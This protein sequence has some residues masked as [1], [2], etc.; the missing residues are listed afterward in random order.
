MAE[1]GMM[2]EFERRAQERISAIPGERQKKESELKQV[3]DTGIA[4][5][6]GMQQ[7]LGES[8]GDVQEQ[9][10][11]G[12]REAQEYAGKSAQ[13]VAFAPTR[14]NVPEL[15][16]LFG[17]L[18]TVAMM[19]GG[20][21]R[22][23]GMGALAAMT[24]AMEGYQKGR[25]DVFNNELKEFDKR[26]REVQ[27]HNQNVR[28]KLNDALKT[29]Q[30]D[31]DAGLAKLKGLEMDIQGS[32]AALNLRRGDIT[33]AIKNLN[34]E[35][36]SSQQTISKYYERVQR[37]REA[38]A[39]NKAILEAARVRAAAADP[40]NKMLAQVGTGG[41]Q[42]YIAE[43]TGKMVRTPK[44]AEAVIFNAQ[45]IDE[46][47]RLLDKIKD[48]DIQTGALSSLA[49]SI[50]KI[51]SAFDGLYGKP[52]SENQALE[53]VEQNLTGNDKTTLF[54]KDAILAA[55]KIEQGLVGSRVPVF[56]QRV[57]GPVL[58][59]RAYT[60]DA[61]AAL[62]K[63]RED[64]LYKAAQYRGFDKKS[65]DTLSDPT[66]PSVRGSATQQAPQPATNL[67]TRENPIR[68]D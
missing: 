12:V 48:K 23:S 29:M 17:M 20:K 31:R 24:G 30:T 16:Q 13:D 53:I 5:I 44:E 45:A 27:L 61:F 37:A 39:R 7:R 38:S 8:V 32:Q 55:F 42:S 40:F 25:K 47:K 10:A 26:I 15:T 67:G 36:N 1:N 50:Q 41:A 33:N 58:D 64:E 14:E 59:P 2:Q 21:G 49:P 65:V 54:I 68:L 6:R 63:R 56:T 9:Y 3:T 34:T 18:T 43:R 4:D 11:G 22:Q 19:A 57:V 51:R 46:I 28:N 35:L 60:K 66:I 52:F 62:L